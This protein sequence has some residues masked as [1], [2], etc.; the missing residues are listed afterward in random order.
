M[1]RITL[2]SFLLALASNLIAQKSLYT[3]ENLRTNLSTDTL[4]F[5]SLLTNE[6]LSNY[7]ETKHLPTH[8]SE[9]PHVDGYTDTLLMNGDTVIS[10]TL[11]ESTGI[12]YKSDS[13]WKKWD[14]ISEGAMFYYLELDT[15]TV[16]QKK[17]L[18]IKYSI[19]DD[20]N[21]YREKAEY[22]ELWN[23][24]DTSRLFIANLITDNYTLYY[25]KKQDSTGFHV[26]PVKS[27]ECSCEQRV[28]FKPNGVN[29]SPVKCAEESRWNEYPTQIVTTDC[30]KELPSGFYSL[31]EGYWIK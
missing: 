1:I 3:S 22:I 26:T 30:L 31:R 7:S 16:C 24:K 11:G 12:A 6:K 21:Y 28:E 20:R 2:I 15:V 10:F 8:T 14:I 29:I 25:D 4:L 27:K 17:L 5:N 19:G 23:L 18:L 13:I 9:D